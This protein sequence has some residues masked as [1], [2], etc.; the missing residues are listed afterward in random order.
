MITKRQSWGFYTKLSVQLA[1]CREVF[2]ILVCKKSFFLLHQGIASTPSG[3]TEGE[4]GFLYKAFAEEKSWN[5]AQRICQRDGGNLAI[6]WNEQTRD[7]VRGFMEEGWIGLTDQWDESNWQTPDR[8]RI[9]YSNWATHEPNDGGWGEDCAEQKSSKR[10]NDV[11]C[12]HTR[13]FICQILP[14]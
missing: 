13:K 4:D 5:D 10:W 3:Y 1:I 8:K 6:I 7:V 12:H 14:G 9:A 11:S 2:T